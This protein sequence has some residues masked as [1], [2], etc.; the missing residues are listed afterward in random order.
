M[1]MTQITYF[2]VKKEFEYLLDMEM[3]KTQYEFFQYFFDIVSKH[4]DWETFAGKIWVRQ[5]LILQSLNFLSY[6]VHGV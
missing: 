5:I 2:G 4:A 6:L 1:N 3:F